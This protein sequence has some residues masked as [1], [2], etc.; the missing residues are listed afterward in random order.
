MIRTNRSA[1]STITHNRSQTSVLCMPHTPEGCNLPCIVY[2]LVMHGHT[3]VWTAH[4]RT[5]I[6]A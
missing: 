3:L 4:S 1:Q 5:D 2:T 6:E